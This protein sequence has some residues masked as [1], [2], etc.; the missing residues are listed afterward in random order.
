MQF[1]F[2]FRVVKDKWI[3]LKKKKKK[4]CL[5]STNNS[6]VTDNIISENLFNN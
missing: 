4:N 1:L 2:Y 3:K 5:K 6:Y